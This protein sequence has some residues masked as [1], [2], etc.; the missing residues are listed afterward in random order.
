[1]NWKRL[2]FIV[3]VVAAIL[4]HRSGITLL[5]VLAALVAFA[6]LI[7]YQ[8][9]CTLGSC[10]TRDNPPPTRNLAQLAAL[11]NRV[12]G[13]IGVVLLLYALTGLYWN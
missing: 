7:S 10:S 5:F 1:M 3:C 6:N 9:S 12:T 4:I 13:F 2:L 8:L 11:V